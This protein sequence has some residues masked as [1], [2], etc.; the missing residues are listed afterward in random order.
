MSKDYKL[1][2]QK[3]GAS[4]HKSNKSPVIFTEEFEDITL[5]SVGKNVYK[6]RWK[7]YRDSEG[8]VIKHENKYFKVTNEGGL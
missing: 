1:R 4:V 6:T 3:T 7:T 5:V 2:G 8:N